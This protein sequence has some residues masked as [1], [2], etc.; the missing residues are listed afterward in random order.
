MKVYIIDST[1]FAWYS[2]KINEYIEVENKIINH[3]GLMAYKIKDGDRIIDI[4]HVLTPQQLREKK[5][6][7][8]INE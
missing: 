3:F 2:N 6:I 7:R 5:I 1:P 4:N 8:I